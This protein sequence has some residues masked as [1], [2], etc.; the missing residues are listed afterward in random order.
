MKK[1]K[2]ELK[3]DIVLK[4]YWRN[5]EQF[6]DLFNAL[7]FDGKQ[8]IEPEEL[9]DIDSEESLIL[10]HKKYAESVKAS[11]DNIKV[12]KNSAARGVEF[13]MLGMESQSHIHYAMPM[14]VMGYDYSAYQKQYASNAVKCQN[15]KE[16]DADEYLSKMKKTDK[17]KPVITAVVYYGEEP[18]DG[19]VTLHGMLDIPQEVEPYVNDSRMLT[20]QSR[21]NNLYFDTQELPDCPL[22]KQTVPGRIVW[23]RNPLLTET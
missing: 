7:L 11:R 21:A 5:N 15:G 22:A 9:T 12:R 3:P 23:R 17:F 16:L 20:I 6:A 19:A 8:M 14:R 2:P 1:R 18:W 4:N 10:E 13:M